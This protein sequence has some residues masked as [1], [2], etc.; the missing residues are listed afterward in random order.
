MQLC[1]RNSHFFVQLQNSESV[2]SGKSSS[3]L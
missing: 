3:F 2:D 1:R